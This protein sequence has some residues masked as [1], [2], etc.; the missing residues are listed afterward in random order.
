ME[1]FFSLKLKPMWAWFR[2][3]HFSFWMICGYLIIEY[4][5]PQSI[6]P[7]LSILPWGQLFLMLSLLGWMAD[8]RARWVRDPINKWMIL[9]LGVIVLSSFN[10]HYPSISWAHFNDFFFWLIIYFLIINIVRTE[11]RLFV[12]LLI[13]ILASYK[14]S[15]HGAR[16]WAFRGFSFT[17]WGLTG[18]PGYFQ[19][20]GEL[21][22]QM[23]MFAPIAYRLAITLKPWLS[24][25]KFWIALGAPITA[26]MTVMGASSRGG[27]LGMLFQLYHTFLKGR[28]NFKTILLVATLAGAAYAF[29]PA[30]Q[31]DR[32]R[33]AGSDKTSE[34]RLLYWKHGLDMIQENPLLGVG[35]FNFAYYYESHFRHDMLYETAQ[36][37]HNIFIQIG[38]DS[39]VL[40]LFIYVMLILGVFRANATV[41]RVLR[42]DKNNWL[43]GLSLGLDA[44]FVGFLIAGQFV[45]VGYYPFMWINMAFSI[46]LKNV[47]VTNHQKNLVAKVAR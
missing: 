8:R 21:T 37:P 6:I 45:T 25:I 39:G 23:L 9:F 33:S 12:F 15:F 13:F 43:Y 3:E 2:K 24:K 38:T 40:G 30:E 4:V 22:I 18:P 14:L 20:S 11:K 10:A 19:N 7:K 17:N 42:Q 29:M 35:Y 5:R 27:Q 36:L 34:Q 46:A 31:L 32:F 16:T 44:A 41:R 26:M 47:V 28:L 1:D